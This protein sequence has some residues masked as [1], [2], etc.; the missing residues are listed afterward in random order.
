MHSFLPT[1]HRAADFSVETDAPI[2]ERR[3]GAQVKDNSRLV[4]LQGTPEQ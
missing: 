4:L 1:A 3:R 2:H